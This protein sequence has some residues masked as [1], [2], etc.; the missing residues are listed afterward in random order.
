MAFCGHFLFHTLRKEYPLLGIDSGLWCLLLQPRETSFA[1]VEGKLTFNQANF[2]GSDFH[3][4]E[5]SI[6]CLSGRWS[7]AIG[8]CGY[9]SCGWQPSWGS[10][11]LRFLDDPI[12]GEGARGIRCAYVGMHGYEFSSTVFATSPLLQFRLFI[13]A[14]SSAI[15]K[16]QNE[17]SQCTN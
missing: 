8:G 17:A 4:K 15:N 16:H 12:A 5:G 14:L 10:L 6:T 9:R 3:K 2:E 7:C 11:P 1:L 13:S